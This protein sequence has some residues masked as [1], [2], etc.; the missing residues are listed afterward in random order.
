M[1]TFTWYLDYPGKLP[2]KPRLLSATFGDGYEQVAGDGLNNNLEEW[3]VQASGI[4]NSIGKDID[5][6]LSGLN[7]ADFFQ[8]TNPMFG[9]VEKNYIC[10]TWNISIDNEDEVSF[11]A[12]FKEWPT[13]V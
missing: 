4:P 12:K 5:D 11:S 7:G 6:F 1:A 13:L 8:W 9:A 10:K 2:R 3:D